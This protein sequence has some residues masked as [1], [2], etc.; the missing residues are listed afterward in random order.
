[1]REKQ[2]NL[3]IE[4]QTDGNIEKQ[5]RIKIESKQ[6][7]IQKANRQKGRRANR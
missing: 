3:K 7:E 5:K 6:I 2:T 1:M 4:K